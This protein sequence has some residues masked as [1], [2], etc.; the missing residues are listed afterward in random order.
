MKERKRM[1]QANLLTKEELEDSSV[2]VGSST[3]TSGGAYG[4]GARQEIAS[5]NLPG[6]F[7]SGQQIVQQPVRRPSQPH[8][9]CLSHTS[10]FSATSS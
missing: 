9:L 2:L 5:A 4:R 10:S 7:G 3:Y 6:G 1:C 8:L